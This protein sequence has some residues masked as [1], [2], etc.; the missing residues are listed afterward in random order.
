MDFSRYI[1]YIKNT[2]GSPRVK[3]FDDDWEPIGPVVRRDMLRAGLITVSNVQE[4]QLT[5]KCKV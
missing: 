2:G 3:Q 5:K 1:S 4:I